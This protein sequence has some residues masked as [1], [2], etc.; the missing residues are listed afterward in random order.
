MSGSTS[1]GQ[2]RTE[3]EITSQRVG[4]IL[5][6]AEEAA[7]RIRDEAEARMNDRITE[8]A[9][10]G[11]AR[12]AA[13]EEEAAELLATARAEAEAERSRSASEALA[14]IGAAEED[15]GRTRK[16]AERDAKEAREQAA[17]QSRE[18]VDEA[19]MVADA[20]RAEGQ[21]ITGHLEDL[22]AS[23]HANAERLT[24]DIRQAHDVLTAGL[25]GV[26][27][28]TGQAPRGDGPS[29]ARRAGPDDSLD[30]P[31]FLPDA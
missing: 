26:R 29:R 6:A 19:R 9:R 30:V 18:L 20:A 23:L 14:T 21:Q 25:N 28:S 2:R 22:S 16:A 8:A 17:A 7:S 13:A 27:T 15:A 5:A 11:N 4:A 1:T 10:A 3:G 24:H 31:E 12:V